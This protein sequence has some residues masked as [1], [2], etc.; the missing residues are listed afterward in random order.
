MIWPCDGKRNTRLRRRT[1]VYRFVFI[2][3]SNDLTRFSC[4]RTMILTFTLLKNTTRIMMLFFLAI[5]RIDQLMSSVAFILYINTV[6]KINHAS[7]SSF[8]ILS[9]LCVDCN[10]IVYY[11]N[12][13]K[14]KYIDWYVYKNYTN[15][16]LKK[17]KTKAVKYKIDLS[18]KEYWN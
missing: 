1:T 3:K 2:L 8:V 12:N 5:T 14:K 6:M 11:N 13:Q 15:E 4:S 7:F 18:M 17:E 9:V 16:R 10:V